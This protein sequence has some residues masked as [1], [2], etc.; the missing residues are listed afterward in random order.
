[1]PPLILASIFALAALLHGAAGIGFPLVLTAILS[2]SLSMK[3]TVVL[4]ALPILLVNLIS[5]FSGG[6]LL[7]ILR[8][9]A[10]L[11]AAATLGSFAGVKLLLILPSAWLQCLLSLLIALY[12]F[13]A[14]RNIVLA[15]PNTLSFT[16]VYGLFAG[17]IGGATNAMSSVL[18][19]YLLA[20]SQDKNEIA[21]AANLCFGLAKIV[22]IALLWHEIIT[23]P[24]IAATLLLPTLA[25]VAALLCGIRLRKRMPFA[26]FRR[27]SLG[28]LALL[29]LMMFGK[30]LAHLL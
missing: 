7:P 21:Q 29:A 8:R 15:M 20:L 22:Q 5:M 10:P 27:L 11:A 30:S 18:M 16:L 26:L 17:I 9:Y 19:M 3:E 14:R 2:L 24:H 4:S 1:M 23:L 6:A 25:A 28:I 12:I 13:C